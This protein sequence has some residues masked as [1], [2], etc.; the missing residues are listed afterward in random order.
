MTIINQTKQ[1]IADFV[2]RHNLCPFAHQPFQHDRIGYSTTAHSTMNAVCESFQ[3]TIDSVERDVVQTALLIYA[4]A[5]PLSFEDFLDLS[6]ILE[7]ELR[8]LN[9]SERYQLATFHPSYQF[10]EVE[11]DDPANATNRSPY[12][13]WHLLRVADVQ[14][15]IENHP[16]T[17]SI[18]QRNVRL[19]R[20]LAASAGN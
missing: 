16:D 18:P 1:W 9:L 10:A 13:M 19:L 15:A 14:D 8:A 5:E 3:T 11:Q 20:N 4:G 7:L 2:L 17:L 6:E 12:P